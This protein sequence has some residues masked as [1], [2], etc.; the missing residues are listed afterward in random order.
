V[1]LWLLVDNILQQ[2]NFKRDFLTTAENYI[3]AA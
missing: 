1:F 3:F 2:S